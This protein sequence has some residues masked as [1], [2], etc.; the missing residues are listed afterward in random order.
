VEEVKKR[1]EQKNFAGG[2][3]PGGHQARISVSSQ[4]TPEGGMAEIVVHCNERFMVC[5]SRNSRAARWLRDKWCLTVCPS[6]KIPDWRLEK[7]STT[8]LNR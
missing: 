7:Y 6:R 2:C 8:G 4:L 1:K 3:R 5:N